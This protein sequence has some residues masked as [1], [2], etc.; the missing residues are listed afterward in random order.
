M[1]KELILEV[2]YQKFAEKGY[3]IPLSEIA[4]AA[5][6]KKQSIY[7]YFKSKDELYFAVVNIYVETYFKEKQ[8]EFNDLNH[9]SPEEQLKTIFMSIIDYYSDTT[10]LRF[11]KWLLLNE[12]ENLFKRSQ[13]S[14]KQHE[15][16]LENRLRE[17]VENALS[18]NHK[19]ETYCLP[20]VR[21]Y[22]AMLHGTL[23]VTMI[24]HGEF[25]IK[26]YAED[27]WMIFWAGIESM[28]IK[29]YTVA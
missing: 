24:Y 12:T 7:N 3:S 1:R 27:V 18:D 6:I 28:I 25:D 22:M 4:E 9:L 21:S 15:H 10:R 17:I 19:A 14:L 8:A 29:D 2:A 20:I 26:N 23:D 5:G 11:W 16:Q 13:S